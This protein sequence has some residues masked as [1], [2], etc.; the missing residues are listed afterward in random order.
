MA[1]SERFLVA[2]EHLFCSLRTAVGPVWVLMSN[3]P[4]AHWL[5]LTPFVGASHQRSNEQVA[6]LKASLNELA[7]IG[8]EGLFSVH[9]KRA[10]V[11]LVE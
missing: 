9:L 7:E 3:A 10:L 2:L 8:N 5:L 6:G 11:L 1:F 4:F